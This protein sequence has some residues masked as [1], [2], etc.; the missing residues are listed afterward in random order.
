MFQGKYHHHRLKI[1]YHFLYVYWMYP[2]CYSF[3]Y[4]FSIRNRRWDCS[5]K[6]FIIVRPAIQQISILRLH[7][8]YCIYCHLKLCLI[9]YYRRNKHLTLY[10][11][12]H[13]TQI[14]GYI[15][16]NKEKINSKHIIQINVNIIN[17]SLILPALFSTA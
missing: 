3:R 4:T 13:K 7:L 14:Y 11:N 6:D 9:R 12:T 5:S 8:F 15:H 2:E 17:K 10:I 1:L 16:N